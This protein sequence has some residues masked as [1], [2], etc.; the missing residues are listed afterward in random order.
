MS[1]KKS[2]K[3]SAKSTPATVSRP[4]KGRSSTAV[5]AL[6]TEGQR[7]LLAVDASLQKIADEVECSK[8]IVG[9]WRQG[10]K[11]PSAELRAKLHAAYAIPPAAWESAPNAEALVEEPPATL[12]D[13]LDNA[14][15]LS[16]LSH[17]ISQ[18][19]RELQNRN[20]SET[21]R[22]NKQDQLTK[23]LG[24]RV[25]I[26]KDKALALDALLRSRDWDAL[27]SDMVGVLRPWPDA[28][29][30]LARWLGDRARARE[31]TA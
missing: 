19:R 20:L 16:I 24:L 9:Y 27:A 18:L 10:K 30:A 7:L 15:P 5:D 28:A 11:L 25:R 14:D 31:V 4:P 29:E 26:E 2:G 3:P 1:P 17:Q 6:E 8:A 13:D 21:A 23:N 12:V 22:S